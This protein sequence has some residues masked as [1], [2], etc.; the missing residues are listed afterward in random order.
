MIILGFAGGFYVGNQ[1]PSAC[2]IRDGEIIAAVEEERLCGEKFARGRMPTRA[3]KNVLKQAGITINDVDAIATTW[4][5]YPDFKGKVED[6]FRFTFGHCPKIMQYYHHL[7]HASSAYY[8]SG[9]EDSKI[10]TYDLSGDN[11]STA[12][13][14]GKGDKIEPVLQVERPNSVGIFYSIITQYLGFDRDSDEYKVMGLAAYQKPSIDL[15]W[16]LKETDKAY[17]LDMAYTRYATHKDTG[18]RDECLFSDAL[19][20]K[21]GMPPRRNEPLNDRHM[22][23]A[24]SCQARLEEVVLSMLKKYVN[25]GEK[26]CVAGGV[27]LNC[28]MNGKFMG[29]GHFGEIYV[30]PAAGDDGLSIGAA[31]LAALELGDKPKPMANAFLGPRYSNDEI[32]KWLDVFQMPY[33]ETDDPCAAAAQLIAEGKIVGWF[34]G[35]MEFGPRALGS[36]SILADPRRAEMKAEINGRVKFREDFRPFAPSAL[37]E[38]AQRYFMQTQENPYM[39]MA[40]PVTDEGARVLPA[41]THANGTARVQTVDARRAPNYHKLIKSFSQIADGCGAVL[42]TSLNVMGQPLSCSPNDAVRVFACSGMDAM[43]LENFVIQKK[44]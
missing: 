6:Y 26:L 40:V 23:L 21:L 43:V 42:N 4:I 17:E 27:G 39:T 37:V 15:S 38:E 7:C 2:I 8:A 36:R 9:F 22:A 32:R 14:H 29:S 18:N 10:V 34:N 31:Y 24:A 28:S 20:A 1:D 35:R 30:Q 16:F 25:P 3:I 5:T 11:I 41:I 19:E 13:W 33:T 44:A 12:I